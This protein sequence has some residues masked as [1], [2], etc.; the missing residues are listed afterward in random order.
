MKFAIIGGTNI[1]T[2][3]I[4]SKEIA[5]TTPYGDAVIQRAVT[6]DGNEILFLSRHGVLHSCD[7]ARVNYRANIYA[8]KSIGVT[9]V[10]GLSTV[11]SCDYTIRSGSLCLFSDFLDFTKSRPSTFNIEHR[12]T[13]HTSMEDVFDPS[14]NDRI[15]KIIL[16]KQVPYAGRT[17]VSCTEGPRFETAAEVR[18]FRNLGAQV[19]DRTVVPEAPLAREVG[20]KYAGI[21]LIASRAT[22]MAD[23]V[24]DKRIIDVMGKTRDSIF[25]I[26]F[27]AVRH[28]H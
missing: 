3:P 18:M 23:E 14:M 11:T 25:G 17:I 16:E 22:G 21:G 20:M 15:E 9:H 7:A 28:I 19:I 1:E 12:L 26:L 13:R 24:S 2:L 27:E 6:E 8:L 5:V 4:P 10:I